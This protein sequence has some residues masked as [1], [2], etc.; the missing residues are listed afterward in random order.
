LLNSTGN[1]ARAHAFAD[2]LRTIQVGE[3]PPIGMPQP[4]TM[5]VLPRSL[6]DAE[7]ARQ[8]GIDEI[9]R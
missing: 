7:C 2:A 3:P 1:R 9:A 4:V 6:G 8:T 5:V